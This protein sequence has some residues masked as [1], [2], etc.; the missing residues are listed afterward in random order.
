MFLAGIA[1]VCEDPIAESRADE[2]VR[3]GYLFWPGTM[4][5]RVHR[6]TLQIIRRLS[7]IVL[8]WRRRPWRL[9]G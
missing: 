5:W 1:N 4:T 2:K 9:V 6:E 8:K 7:M 3:V